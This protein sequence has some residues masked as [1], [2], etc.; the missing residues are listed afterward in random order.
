MSGIIDSAGSRSG[1][2]G[3][4]ELDY[5]EGTWTAQ[6]TDGTTSLTMNTNY[7]TGD[8]IKVGKLVT[9]TGLFM[10]TG[11]NGLTS[12]TIRI[13]GLPFTCASAPEGYSGSG[14]GYGA[15]LGLAGAGQSV[16]YITEVENTYL[17]LF[18]WDATGGVTGMTAS[19]WG[20]TGHIIVG[21]SYRVYSS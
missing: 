19:E 13:T 15:N 18:V 8:Y 4:T 12:Q 5:E 7:I 6:L 16:G 2:I 1:V 14:A 3:T 17:P 11:L 10:T 21:L 9:V 20:A